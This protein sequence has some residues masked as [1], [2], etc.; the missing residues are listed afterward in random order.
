MTHVAM[1]LKTV[2]CGIE[3]QRAVN[4]TLCRAIVQ[5]AKV[6]RAACE[7]LSRHGHLH[8]EVCGGCIHAF[9]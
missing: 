6:E 5:C 4:R 7:M 1:C 9:C 8:K 3:R 2:Y